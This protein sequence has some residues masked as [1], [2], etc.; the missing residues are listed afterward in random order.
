MSVALRAFGETDFAEIADFWVAAWV[1]TG[2]D[3]DFAA[4]R[5]WLKAHLATMATEGVEII[6]ACATEGAVVAFVTIDRGSGYLDQLCVAP[7]AQGR[8]VAR[9]LVNEAK[10]L[11]PG[12]VALSVNADNAP[13][14][15]LYESAGFAV[16]AQ[17][18][19]SMSGR[20]TLHLLW[21][22]G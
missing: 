9:A 7:A 11:A 8:G 14:R 5:P 16:V 17:G 3:V 2:I 22:C 12:R 20:P 18:V 13:A 6:V 21:T 1:A 4:R 10:R 15:A 19:S